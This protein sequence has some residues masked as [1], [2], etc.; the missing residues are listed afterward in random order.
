MSGC[1]VPGRGQVSGAKFQE[2]AIFYTD[3]PFLLTASPDICIVIHGLVPVALYLEPLR[4]CPV[5]SAIAAHHTRAA[6]IRFL[7]ASYIP[8]GILTDAFSNVC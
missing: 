6:N 7:L 3:R 1:K 4:L 5:W 2:R 8:V